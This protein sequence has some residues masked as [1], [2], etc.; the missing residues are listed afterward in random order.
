MS[1][2]IRISRQGYTNCPRCKA[3]VRVQGPIA[4]ARCF[5]CESL[6]VGPGDSASVESGLSRVV[7]A[8]RSGL[9]AASLLGLGVV[10]GCDGD[11]ENKG[12]DVIVDAAPDM[13]VAPV[14]GE[15]ADVVQSPEDTVSDVGPG[16]PADVTAP[17]AAQEDTAPDSVPS[18]LYGLP[19]E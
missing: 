16:E 15:P 4:E 17:D 19:P 10:S 7:S 2:R 3:H 14:Y 1:P 9:L 6:I 12:T 13:S 11:T 8:G 18:A 5:F